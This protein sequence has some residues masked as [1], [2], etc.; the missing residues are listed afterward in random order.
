[1]VPFPQCY[2]IS[3]RPCVSWLLSNP[4]LV[5][6]FS[7]VLFD[8]FSLCVLCFLFPRVIWFH[9]PLCCGETSKYNTIQ[10][11]S[12]FPPS[13][14]CSL[15]FLFTVK[16]SFPPLSGDSVKAGSEPARP[17][18]TRFD[19]E[20]PGLIRN[21]PNWRTKSGPGLTRLDP[22]WPGIARFDPEWP[23]LTWNI[24][25]N[26]VIPGETRRIQVNPGQLT[27]SAKPAPNCIG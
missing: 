19:P 8:L 16:F 25:G 27:K 13:F 12:W 21:D 4:F 14:L 9:F 10:N 26:R 1:M 23:E 7:T 6:F 18:L 11:N 20:W 24:R 22:E 17:G 3:F 15:L 5:G 2:L